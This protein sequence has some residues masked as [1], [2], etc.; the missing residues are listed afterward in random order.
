MTDFHGRPEKIP[1]NEPY[2]QCLGRLS[3]L[4]RW[5]PTCQYER[6]AILETR[7][8]TRQFGDLVAVD[9][10]TLRIEAGDVFRAARL[11]RRPEDDRQRRTSTPEL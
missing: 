8:L 2:P 10:L 4:E 9:R 3:R 6:M 5:Q 1:A 11:E 7:D